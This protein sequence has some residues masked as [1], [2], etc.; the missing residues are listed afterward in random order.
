MKTFIKHNSTPYDDA[1]LVEY[2]G[3]LQ[4]QKLLEG[5]SAI[6]IPQIIAFTPNRLEIEYIVNSSPSDEEMRAFGVG[7]ANM[8]RESFEL[9]G[10]SYDNYI[11]LNPQIN[12]VPSNWGRF[13]F[14]KR[15]LS[16]VSMI[17]S[18][19]LRLEFSALLKKHSRKIENFLNATTQHPSLVH[20]DLWSGNVLFSKSGIY[21]I[22]PAT[23]FADRE[24]DIAMTEMFGGF[25]T[26]FYESYNRTYPLSED[27][28]IKKE[29]YN[30]YH[31]LNHYNLFGETY[32]SDCISRFELIEKL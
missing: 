25:S 4:L 24:V 21:L 3:L 27:Y 28:Q 31:Y 11:G 32:L 1:L 19:Q 15:V 9:Y 22:D 16:Q 14:E 17:K 30:L 23:Y 29:L 13:F 26:T 5:N 2:K 8:H 7:L 10:L 12:G 6:K 18:A 20:G